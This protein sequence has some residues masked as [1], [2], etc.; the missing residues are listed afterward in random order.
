MGSS[1]FVYLN[2][3]LFSPTT[4]YII[5][6]LN[7][8]I[9]LGSTQHHNQ[10][11]QLLIKCEHIK[12]L[13]NHPLPSS[14]ARLLPIN[15]TFVK[16]GSIRIFFY[17]CFAFLDPCLRRDDEGYFSKFLL[18]FIP[19]EIA[20]NATESNGVEMTN[21]NSICTLIVRIMTLYNIRPPNTCFLK[22]SPNLSLTTKRLMRSVF[23]QTD[24]PFGDN[25]TAAGND[26]PLTIPLDIKSWTANNATPL[27]V[28]N[29]TT[30]T[31]ARSYVTN[32]SV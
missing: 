27:N 28:Q 11:I 29:Q 17:F 15:N 31:D 8:Y 22:A 24:K 32:R 12:F 7:D 13:F 21:I 9:Q 20:L 26:R 5:V 25:L 6:A 10:Y 23:Y 16:P 14:R 4:I 18:E 30:A 19:S 2:L 3:N 1:S